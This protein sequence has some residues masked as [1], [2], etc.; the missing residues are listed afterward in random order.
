MS[1]L[2]QLLD[3]LS[4]KEGYNPTLVEGIGVYRASQSVAREPLCYRQGIIV[5]AQGS[6]RVYLGEEVYDYNPS[7]Y[8]VMTLPIPAECETQVVPGEPLLALL[9][10]I[11][12]ELLQPLIRLFDDHHQSPPEA[13]TAP[14][15][16]GLYVSQVTDAFSAATVRLCQHLQSPLTAEALCDGVLREILYL[17][18]SSEHSAPLFE[19][20]R[21][22][23]QLARMER[24]LKYMHEH[25]H[26][27]LEVDRLAALAGMSSSSFHRNFR[28][29]T[30]SPPLQ[31]LKKLRLTRARELLQDKDIKV[32]QAAASVGYESPTQFSRE[33]KRYFGLSPQDSSGISPAA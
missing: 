7:H 8:L 19:L 26:E 15:K 23:T 14:G 1:A 3:S 2:V 27:S 5:V 10:D 17:I 16:P 28:Q 31:Y 4:P 25:Y 20:A 12:M 21:Y 30:G 24:V 11:K 33:F 22:N 13:L 6:K 9:I 29:S 32:K 18:L